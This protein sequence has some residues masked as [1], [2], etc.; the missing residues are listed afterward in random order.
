MNVLKTQDMHRVNGG[1]MLFTAT[2]GNGG[3]YASRA[4]LAPVAD[5]RDDEAVRAT[6]KF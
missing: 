3:A 2:A 5:Y 6:I 1:I 4:C